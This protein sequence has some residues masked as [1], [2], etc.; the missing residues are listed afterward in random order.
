LGLLKAPPKPRGPLMAVIILAFVAAA[1]AERVRRPVLRDDPVPLPAEFALRI[2]INLASSAELQLLP[3]VGRRLA[4]RIADDRDGLGRF[5][6]IEDLARV[7]GI[8]AQT[9][10]RLRPHAVVSAPAHAH[11]QP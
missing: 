3:G 1:G 7:R 6:S 2:D 4:E 10:E 5:A 11:A 9:I 8:G